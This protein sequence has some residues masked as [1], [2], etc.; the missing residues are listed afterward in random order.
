M[1]GL[2]RKSKNRPL[3]MEVN[4]WE[5]MLQKI[6]G[7]S[8]MDV[9]LISGRTRTS[10]VKEDAFD[11]WDVE[12]LRCGPQGISK[13]I[14]CLLHLF[15]ATYSHL[16]LV[17]DDI[18]FYEKQ[19]PFTL[20][21]QRRI[22][23][24]LNT[25]VYNGSFHGSGGQQ[26]RP[27]MDAAVRCLHLLYERDCRH[28]F[29]P[30][31]LWLSPARNNRP[32][33]AVAARTH[34][35]LSAKPDDALTI[36]SMAPVITTTHVFPFEESF[37]PRSICSS[38]CSLGRV[39]M[40]REF[41]KMDKFSRKMAGEVAGPGSRSVE[42][43]I[44]PSE[45]G[46][47]EAGLDYG[48]LF[49][50]FLTD[51][52]KAAFAPEYG[53]FSQTST[54]DRLLVPNTAARFLYLGRY[55]FLDELS[56]LD[57]ELY[58]NLMY[59][60]H[61]DGDVKELSLDFT[62]TE[63]SLGKRHIIELKPGGKDAIVTNENK[64][65]YVHAMADY[66]LNRQ[67]LP[68][69][70]AFYRGT[71][72]GF[73]LYGISPLWDFIEDWI[74]LRFQKEYDGRERE[75]E[76][77]RE[78]GGVRESESA[79]DG[80]DEETGEASRKRSFTVESKTF[81]LAMDGRKGRCQILIVEKKRGISTWVRLGLESLGLFKEG[82]IHCIRDDKE[83][84]WEKE[85]RERGKRFT[86]VRGFN[87]AGGFLRLGVVDLER[88]NFSIFLPRG[89]RDKRG[90][91]AMVEM[92]R[93][94][95]ELAERRNCDQDEGLEGGDGWK[96]TEVGT[97]SRR[98][99][100]TQQEGRRQFGEAGKSLGEFL[101]PKRVMGGVH[102]GL[103]LWN[104]K[105][106][107]WGR[108][109]NGEF[110]PSTL[111]IEVKEE[112]YTLA[113]WWEIRPVVRRSFSTTETSRRTE[114][115]KYGSG[116]ETQELDPWP[117]VPGPGL[118]GWKNG[119]AVFICPTM[120][121]KEQEKEVGA[122]RPIPED[123]LKCWVPEEI[124][125]EQREDGF[126]MIDRALED[127]AKRGVFRSP[128]GIEEELWGDKST[129]LTIYEGNSENENGSW[130]LGEANKN[131]DKVR[132]KEGKETKIQEMSEGIVR[133][134]GTGR[135]ID[136]RALN[137]E[138]AAGGIL[139]CWD[140]RLLDILDWEEGHF[141]LSCRFKTIENGATWVFTGVYGP[142]TKVEREGMWEEFGAIRGLWDDPWCLG[143][144]F[145]IILFNKKEAAKEESGI[146]VRGSAS[147][148][149][150][151]KMKEIKK[152]LKVWNKEA[153][154]R[155]ETNKALALEQVDFWDQVES[156]RN[157]TVE[158]ADLKKD[159]KDSFKKWILIKVNGEWLVEEQE[160][161]ERV[162]NSFQQMLSEDM[163]WQADIGNI[164]PLAGRFYCSLLAKRMDFT[165]EEI[166]EMFK[167]F[168][169]HNSFVRSL[170]NTFLVLIP[171]KSG[172]EDL[173]D[174]RPISLFFKKWALGPSG[175]DG[176]GAVSSAKFSILVNGVPAGFF[177]STRGLR[178]GDPLS[179]YLFVM[180]ME[181]LDVLIRRA[182]EGGYLTGCNI[183]GGS[184]SSLNISH[185][186]FA[187]G[188]IVFCE[189]N[190]E[191]V[192][193]LSWILF[194]FEAASGLR[195]NLAKSEIIPVGEVEEILEMAVELGCKG[196]VHLVKWD[197]VCTEK[198][199]GGLGLRRIATLNRAL[200][201]KW[202]WRFACEK[203][204]LWKQVISMK[205][206]QE[207]YGWRAKKAS[208]AAGVGVWKEIMKESEWCW[209]NL[210]FLVGKGS[211][212]KFWK[213]SWC[214]DTPLSQCFNHLFVLA[215]HRD[216]TIEEM[217]DQHSG[218]GDWNL[219]FVR[220]FNDWK[221]I[222]VKEAYRLLDKP[223]ATEFPARRIW[224]DRVPIK[225]SFFAWEATWGKVLTL[226]RLQK[227]G[228]LS[229]GNHDIDI[230]DL[231]NHTRYT[232]GYTEGSR[233]V[234]LFW[235]V[236]TG[237]EPK[238]RC[239]LLKFVTSC[240]RAPL[241]GFKHL[242]P[243]FTIHKVACDVPLWA[244]IGGQDVER[245][246]SASTCYNTLKLP[247]YK[248]PSTLRASFYMQSI[249]MQGLNFLRDLA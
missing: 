226:D 213:D 36:P 18:E 113:L 223:N 82:L 42:V 107:C 16:L 152:N 39:Q 28:Q 76:G 62:V 10:Q 160:V 108:K 96:L 154:G 93:Q 106:G 236:I 247:T 171:K 121:L 197:V 127:E 204:N 11:V 147:Y 40:F 245:L 99:L 53:L 141:T 69:S 66:K 98:E 234:K 161:R 21:Q 105:T 164:Q 180:G 172:A 88:K 97:L 46:L 184:R 57:P 210:A 215:V 25:L 61:Y 235:E 67:M 59:V 170:N 190:K 71:P 38:I 156:E 86:L 195:I 52:A 248:R 185:L 26:N 111:E 119:W 165:K 104:P 65:Q 79:C 83:G 100:E 220:D 117:N 240:S 34:E 110:R 134:L 188:T 89:R 68:L 3:E 238:E 221:W 163:V 81:E 1:M 196:K 182:V 144:D 244:T 131:R 246:P 201:G 155:L 249:L 128:K 148:R 176:C 44:R 150:A 95:E 6:T 122:K 118:C 45:C 241:L 233:T 216:A 211:K 194:W 5:T 177:P 32:P 43:V 101:G 112:V 7:K 73:D 198:F 78:R 35:V 120:D 225:V 181:I 90:W 115:R 203:D 63:E 2:M 64:L 92:I 51:I 149:L 239:M 17:L 139:I 103:D 55:S 166:M 143:G 162:V 218:Q 50:E 191:Q 33:I 153:F 199:N 178:Q 168:H 159:A 56:T 243:T 189:A 146:D 60:K 206:E 8:Q 192:S 229:G 41:I 231:R 91:T 14:S 179:P 13:D 126:S 31:G 224:V 232:G 138:G 237:F 205:Y 87:R 133:S 9:D 125:R 74:E 4:K 135:F 222:W 12:P 77:T 145:N 175:W 27:L 30:P 209:E 219:V 75:R 116:L 24:M 187:D 132:C 80:N 47:P 230:T 123:P 114:I 186:F 142:F 217:W 49:K 20:E 94:M 22:A 124:R 102:L 23:S 202:I 208:G 70:N 129:W 137:A 158:E 84:R 109:G 228:L 72:W 207:E 167:E 19:V 48:G 85:W 183:R 136:W 29:C 37:T 151:F 174:F 227:R 58:R 200:L 157:L 54:S 130:K 173:E 242:Q 214:T 15:C 193:H 212:I 140:K 169:E